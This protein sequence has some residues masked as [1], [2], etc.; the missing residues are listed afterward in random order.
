M[1]FTAWNINLSQNYFQHSILRAF[2]TTHCPSQEMPRISPRAEIN[3][4]RA[5]L[6]SNPV[7]YI[8]FMLFYP[9]RWTVGEFE[10]MATLNSQQKCMFKVTKVWRSPHFHF[11]LRA[12]RVSPL[13]KPRLRG[14]LW[15]VSGTKQ[16]KHRI[17]FQ[18]LVILFLGRIT[19]HNATQK[20]KPWP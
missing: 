1:T 15:H 20:H 2:V 12:V 8:Y 7:C 6:I 9:K 16:S 14:S 18:K 5:K 19:K 17:T 10:S 13:T 11:L 3:E 4:V